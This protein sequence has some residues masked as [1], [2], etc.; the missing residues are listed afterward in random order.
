MSTRT[1]RRKIEALQHHIT[2]TLTML[3]QYYSTLQLEYINTS[4]QHQHH[5]STTTNA[6]TPTPLQHQY[7]H[8]NTALQHHI[9][10]HQHTTTPLQHQYSTT[11]PVQHYTSTA[12]VQHQNST[13]T[14]PTSLHS[15]H[16]YSLTHSLTH[17]LPPSLTHLAAKGPTSVS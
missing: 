14:A 4:L 5:Y 7:Q 10:V 3:P 1:Q 13:R 15:T 11:A 16:P 12:P 2:I 6:P 9:S 17:S 8:S